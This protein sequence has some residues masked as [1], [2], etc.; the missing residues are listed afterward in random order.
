MARMPLVSR[1]PFCRANVAALF[2]NPSLG[3]VLEVG[4]KRFRSTW[5]SLHS[6]EVSSVQAVCTWNAPIVGPAPLAMHGPGGG[7]A[8]SHP[9]LDAPPGIPSNGCCGIPLADQYALN[10]PKY[11]SKERFS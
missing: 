11:V 6:G 5:L 8:G 3:P 1:R 7:D 10:C 4:L 9:G 2:T